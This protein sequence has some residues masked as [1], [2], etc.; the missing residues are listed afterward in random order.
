M[1]DLTIYC[2]EH[3][4]SPLARAFGGEAEADCPLALEII[5]ADREEIKRLNSEFRK[6]DRETDVLSFPTLENICGKALK[7]GDFP[8]D[9]DEDGKLFLG[10][11]VICTD[12]AKEQA[13]E[14]GHPYEREL[15]YLATHGVCHL[16]G[17][18]HEAE[19]DKR[20]MREKEER[21][22]KKLNLTREE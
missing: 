11:V 21:V 14:Y 3:D 8:Y 10:S 7:A 16:F 1:I 12:V 4:F 15:Y 13:Q 18:D 9:T 5:F 6:I 22:L 17:Y 19:E 20:E 2:D